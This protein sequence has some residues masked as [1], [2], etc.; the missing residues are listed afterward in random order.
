NR[1]R[2]TVQLDQMRPPIFRKDRHMKGNKVKPMSDETTVLRNQSQWMRE[3]CAPSA[4]S[5]ND[6]KV[7]ILMFIFLG[8]SSPPEKTDVQKGGLSL[9]WVSLQDVGCAEA[10]HSPIVQR[11]E[12]VMKHVFVGMWVAR[13]ARKQDAM[14]QVRTGL[15]THKQLDNISAVA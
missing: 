8:G 10:M 7:A 5:S 13:P 15:P 2:Q 12:E 9:C 11:R 1:W 6:A 3:F 4:T 14:A